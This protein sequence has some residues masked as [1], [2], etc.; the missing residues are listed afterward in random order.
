MPT[1]VKASLRCNSNSA[2]VTWEPASGAL[3]YVAVGVTTD[4]RY[5]TKCN[6][7]MTYCDLS[8]LQCGQT[9]NVSVFGYDDSCSG[10]ESDKAFVRTAPCM[11]QN[12]SVESRC[13]EGAMVV[14][15]S[16]NPDAQYFHVAAVSN[17]GARLYCNSSSTKCTINNL[18]CGQSYNITVLS[19]RDAC[20]S[21][22]SAVAKTS[23]VPCVPQLANGRLDCLSNNAWVSWDPAAGATSYF[24]MAQAANGDSFNCTTSSAP[25]GIA[26]LKCGTLYTFA[27]M[28][29]NDYCR[30][31]HS[32]PFD[33]V[34]GPCTLETINAT[35]ECN[36]GTIL[37][38]WK[39]TGDTS[40][41]LVTAVA[42]DNT[43]I[44]CNSSSSSCLLQ[45]A[46]CDTHYSV[47]V[48]ASSDTCGS[49]RS[50]LTKI[51]TAPCVPSNVTV[52]SLCEKNVAAVS[53]AASPVASS[54]QLTATGQDG[55]KTGCSSAMSNCSL[56]DLHCGQTYSF[57]I[58]ANGGNCT[59]FPSNSTFKTVPC[60]PQNV[61]Y[62]GN[63]QSALLSWDASVLATKYM[64][65]STSGGNR[66]VLC[67]TTMLACWLTNFDPSTT[68]VTANDAVG[69][70][71]PTKNITG[72][73]NARRRRDAQ[74]TE[75]FST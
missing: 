15:W 56:V 24:S 55:H 49:L 46:R 19:V 22:P 36:S 31:N 4:G 11:P 60:A 75:L 73:V 23:S 28:A 41:Y 34:T 37:V 59:S 5:Q 20:E 26:N 47:V 70:S 13:A 40:T 32:K 29:I 72:P 10:M 53:W 12:V 48:S 42:D 33:L 61:K 35:S 1:N 50:P 57:S 30:S 54:Y 39:K 7:T 68:E 71:I 64:V 27:V 43:V 18:P 66:A 63:N 74:V 9:Y 58:T 8:N 44:S 62:S 51:T 52:G 17:T 67:N 2:A 69:E 38:E 21:K 16:P 14:S 45:G 25:C 3:A 6:N 65:Y